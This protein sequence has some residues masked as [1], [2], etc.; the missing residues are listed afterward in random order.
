MFLAT[1]NK[2]K[3]LLQLSY[4]GKVDVEELQRGIGE[5]NGLLADL[6]AGLKILVDLSHLEFMDIACA[7]IL[8]KMME[9][10]EAHG[11]ELIVRVIPDPTKDIG[12]NIIS[13]FHY[14]HR[15]RTAICKTMAEAASLLAI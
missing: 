2:S 11:V 4:I 5:A 10:V 3:R 12:F 8:G 9:V 1:S 13:T 15:P 6:P 7:E 14:Q